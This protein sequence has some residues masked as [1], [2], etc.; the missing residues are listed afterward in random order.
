VW[1]RT[2][3]NV[4]L[5]LHDLLKARLE[6]SLGLGCAFTWCRRLEELPV[7]RTSVTLLAVHESRWTHVHFTCCLALLKLHETTLEVLGREFLV[8]DEELATPIW[9]VARIN[10]VQRT[11]C[12]FIQVSTNFVLRGLAKSNEHETERSHLETVKG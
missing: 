11:E 8:V 4:C 9:H 6:G 1:V 5:Y 10:S 3:P 12:A 2:L 7:D